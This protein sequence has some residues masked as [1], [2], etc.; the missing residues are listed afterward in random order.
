MV[1]LHRLD[2]RWTPRSAVLLEL[3]G[4]RVSRIADFWHVTWLLDA[5]D[6]VVLW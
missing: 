1:I 6:S 2:N 3:T 5:A 4:G